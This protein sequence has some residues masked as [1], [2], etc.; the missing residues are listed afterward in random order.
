MVV[1]RLVQNLPH[2][3][4]VRTIGIDARIPMW[5][6]CLLQ[7]TTIYESCSNTIVV[8]SSLA[9]DPWGGA[10]VPSHVHITILATGSLFAEYSIIVSHDAQKVNLICN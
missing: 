10:E 1:V 7:S 2:V 9:V 8:Q 4:Q 3:V 6:M 5:D